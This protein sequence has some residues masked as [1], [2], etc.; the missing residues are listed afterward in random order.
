MFADGSFFLAVSG[1][2]NGMTDLYV[3]PIDPAIPRVEVE[4]RGVGD[5]ILWCDGER[6]FGVGRVGGVDGGADDVFAAGEEH[7]GLGRRA[8]LGRRRGRLLP[9]GARAFRTWEGKRLRAIIVEVV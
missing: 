6:V 3:R 2:D 7:E 1:Y 4:G 8:R 9:V 5:E